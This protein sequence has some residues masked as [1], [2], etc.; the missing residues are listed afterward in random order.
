MDSET[1]DL[2][3]FDTAIRHYADTGALVAYMGAR[4]VLTLDEA[5][6]AI[7]PSTEALSDMLSDKWREK[8][9]NTLVNLKTRIRRR[10][11]RHNGRAAF[12][13]GVEYPQV[14]PQNTNALL[15]D[16]STVTN[17]IS[18]M[19]QSFRPQIY[20]S[21]A[22]ADRYI[23][24]VTQAIT[25]S[26]HYLDKV[27]ATTEHG[28][29]ILS[30]DATAAHLPIEPP[31]NRSPNGWT[32]AELEGV[33]RKIREETEKVAQFTQEFLHAT[34]APESTGHETE[35][36]ARVMSFTIA[37]LH[38]VEAQFAQWLAL[39]FHAHLFLKG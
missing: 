24:T 38:V 14:T 4:G 26:T 36:Y 20:S 34:A 39:A 37:A 10:I 32:V 16:L 15:S 25:R 29:V 23:E 33:R 13:A 9:K 31:S 7:Y 3:L 5:T 11:D 27:T 28:H 17:M 19:A 35:Q 2:V 12:D 6:A 18:V 1:R 30:R 22:A 21:E 8:L